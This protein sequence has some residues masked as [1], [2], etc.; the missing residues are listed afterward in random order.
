MDCNC[1]TQDIWKDVGYLVTLLISNVLSVI[2][3]KKSSIDE[4]FKKSFRN[5]HEEIKDQNTILNETTNICLRE[6]AISSI[7]SAHIIKAKRKTEKLLVGEENR[8]LQLFDEINNSTLERPIVVSFLVFLLIFSFYIFQFTGWFS[9]I[10]DSSYRKIFIFI[11]FLCIGTF[12]FFARPR[13]FPLFPIFI[14]L[15]SLLTCFSF[16]IKIPKMIPLIIFFVAVVPL[17]LSF[18]IR[19][20][21]LARIKGMEYIRKQLQFAPKF[22]IL[23]YL[24]FIVCLNTIIW[25]TLF[26]ADDKELVIKLVPLDILFYFLIN[27]IIFYFFIRL[28]LEKKLWQIFQRTSLKYL[29]FDKKEFNIKNLPKQIHFLNKFQLFAAS[30]L[31]GLLLRK[32]QIDHERK[33]NIP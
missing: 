26:L 14:I 16:E 30:G 5:F 3:F 21:K 15:L 9:S 6:K 20:T 32:I 13:R 18:F 31:D 29:S 4:K 8:T 23:L 28:H 1:N 24:S 17:T 10:G 11:Y 19:K 25:Q 2:S 27:V 22:A 12:L 33:N 7:I